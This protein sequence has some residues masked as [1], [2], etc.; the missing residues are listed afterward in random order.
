MQ[1]LAKAEGESSIFM[2]GVSTYIE[3]SAF[4]DFLLLLAMRLRANSW[5]LTISNFAV[6]RTISVAW[7]APRN[8][9]GF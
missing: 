9:S 8:R 2:E 4:K 6:F 5:S 3:E 7:A 1:K